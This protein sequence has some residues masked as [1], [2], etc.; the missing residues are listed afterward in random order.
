MFSLEVWILRIFYHTVKLLVPIN[1]S[2]VSKE[3]SCRGVSD[4]MYTCKN[5]CLRFTWQERQ[6]TQEVAL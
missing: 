5:N 2:N 3:I 1:M 6:K 4:C